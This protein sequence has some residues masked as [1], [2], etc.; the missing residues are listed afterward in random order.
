MRFTGSDEDVRLDAHQ[1]PEF[2]DWRWVS[3]DQITDLIVPFKRRVY[4]AVLEEFAGL[5]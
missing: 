1:P 3:P 2:C 5:L 4:R